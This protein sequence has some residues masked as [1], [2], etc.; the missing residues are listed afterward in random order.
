[1]IEVSG[2]LE[3]EQV[4][5]A[6]L[7]RLS[8]WATPAGRAAGN[9]SFAAGAAVT[10]VPSAATPAE[11]D[12]FAQDCDAS[13]WGASGGMRMWQL[14]LHGLFR[15]RRLDVVLARGGER[16]K[17]GQCAVG[18]G[19]RLRVFSDGLQ[20]RPG[21]AALWPAAMRA[22]IDA[23]GPGRYVYG[24]FWSLEAPRER[25]L[26]ALPGVTL[27]AAR[28]L[29]VE[30]V[31]FGRFA[32]WDECLRAVSRNV[33]R[34]AR[35]ARAAEPPPVLHQRAG[36]RA[37]GLLPALLRLRGSMYGRKAVPFSRAR[38][39]ATYLLRCGLL[40]RRAG[41]ALLC[42]DGAPLAAAGTVGFGRNLFYLDGGSSEVR[43]GAGWYLLLH[44]MQQWQAAHPGGRFVMG[45]T[46]LAAEMPPDGWVSPVRYR[47]DCRVT[48]TRTSIVAFDVGGPAPGGAIPA[49]LLDRTLPCW[50]GPPSDEPAGSR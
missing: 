29:A 22:V 9:G 19:L 47:Q 7:L 42:A 45:Y 46:D 27:V 6:L 48:A 38:A 39:A 10:V 49:L 43:P 8:S 5:P 11:W 2:V 50:T 40:G 28:P 36:L 32:T 17:I 4:A 15:L 26:A 44:L 12:R 41:A 30:A 21:D 35:K 16:R 37:L 3:W 34:N 18:V 20:L 25:A 24:S 33:V 31:E 1:M 23:L 13:F 14:K